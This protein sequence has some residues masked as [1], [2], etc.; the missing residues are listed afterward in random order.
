MVNVLL[1]AK[2]EQ[3]PKVSTLTLVLIVR[4]CQSEFVITKT[5]KQITGYFGTPVWIAKIAPSYDCDRLCIAFEYV[6]PLTCLLE[7]LI[8]APTFW[9]RLARSN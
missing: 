3:T 9:H 8:E 7:Q 6:D 1:S 2:L 5:T 4:N